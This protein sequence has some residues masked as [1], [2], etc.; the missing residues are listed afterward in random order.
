MKISFRAFAGTILL[1]LAAAV[2]AFASPTV[3]IDKNYSTGEIRIHVSE[4]ESGRYTILLL[5][6]AIKPEEIFDKIPQED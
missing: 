6:D 3:G 1:S 2:P 5:K 4:E